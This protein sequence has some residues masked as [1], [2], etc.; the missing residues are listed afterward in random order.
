MNERNLVEEYGIIKRKK[1]EVDQLADSLKS[2]LAAKEQAIVSLLLS[3]QA[4]STAKY[5]GIGFA[6]IRKP[7]IKTANFPIDCQD[8]FFKFVEDEGCKEIIKL[9]IHPTTLR[10]FVKNILEEG[11]D[12]PPYLYYEP[13]QKITFYDRSDS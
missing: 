13:I 8:D 1:K 7:E 3:N 4:K 9:N 10:S 2:Q 12:L 6:N 5:D 11:R